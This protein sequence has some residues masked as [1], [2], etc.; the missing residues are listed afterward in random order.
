MSDGAALARAAAGFI[1]VRFR[2]YGR[3]PRNGLDC[4]GLV[5]AALA[6]IGRRPLSLGGYGL[7]NR[8]V[9][10][11]FLEAELSGLRRVNDR[12]IMGD[13]VLISPSPLQHHLLIAESGKWAIHAH[14]TLR[15]VVREPILPSNRVV[16]QWRP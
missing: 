10:H 15:R 7:H 16:A 8:T 14:A 12:A 2:L 4:V 1:G 13:I 6:E 9:S 5:S 11:W 3:E